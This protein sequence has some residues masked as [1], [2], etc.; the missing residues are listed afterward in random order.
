MRTAR[1]MQCILVFYSMME[2]RNKKIKANKRKKRREVE[3]SFVE[4]SQESRY[5]ASAANNDDDE[6]EE[7]DELAS[8]PSAFG[9]KYANLVSQR[10]VIGVLI[11]LAVVPQLDVQELDY[12]RE[13]S[14][15]QLYKWGDS[16]VLSADPDQ[17][18]NTQ[19]TAGIE[20]IQD[21][22]DC[23]YFSNFGMVLKDDAATIDRRRKVRVRVKGEIRGRWLFLTPAFLT[24][25]SL[26]AGRHDQVHSRVRGH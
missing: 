20:F 2:A 21:F 12:S 5:A 23:L 16:C 18:N 26:V 9:L 22:D 7:D 3:R 4:D 6:D 11:I 10:V 24:P 15:D 14:M 1:A 17:C 25:L 8:K 13:A 19:T